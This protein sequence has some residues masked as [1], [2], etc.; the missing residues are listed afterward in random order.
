MDLSEFKIQR[1]L[2]YTPRLI[3]FCP[4][5]NKIEINI[6]N[7]YTSMKR[8]TETKENCQKIRDK[9]RNFSFGFCSFCLTWLQQIHCSFLPLNSWH[10]SLNPYFFFQ[11]CFRFFSLCK[12]SPSQL[13]VTSSSTQ[14]C[15]N[16]S[17]KTCCIIN[18]PKEMFQAS[19]NRSDC[20]AG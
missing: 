6:K 10:S 9:R 16:L 18:R 2:L 13:S 11:E 4:Q 1:Q 7:F 3:E 5:R 12:S 14:F 20:S 19:Q 17:L 8:V 15:S